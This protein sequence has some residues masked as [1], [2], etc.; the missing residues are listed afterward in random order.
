VIDYLPFGRHKGVSLSDSRVSDSYVTWLASTCKLGHGLR[1]AV[2]DELR[3]RGL[4]IPDDPDSERQER[5]AAA[6]EQ[7]CIRCGSVE[8]RVGWMVFTSGRRHLR[9][10]CTGCSAALGF[11]AQTPPNIALA[12]AAE[13]HLETS[14]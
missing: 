6:R 11:L 8:R 3:R 14:L 1:T 5:L 12:D 10:T 4:P 9:L 7:P 2:E 13:H